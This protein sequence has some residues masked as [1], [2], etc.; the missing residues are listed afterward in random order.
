[1]NETTHARVYRG[2]LPLFLGLVAAGCSAP[3]DETQG[4]TESAIV[5]G[6]VDGGHPNVGAIYWD[7]T[8]DDGRTT[9]SI[10]TGTVVTATAIVSAAHCVVPPPGQHYS[11]YRFTLDRIVNAG[12][13]FLPIASVVA[14]PAYELGTFGG[15]YDVSVMRLAAPVDVAPARLA[16]PMNEAAVGSAVVPVGYGL[17]DG[18]ARTGSGTK[19]SITVKLTAI[20]ANEFTYGEA[21]R[22]VCGGDSGGPVFMTVDGREVIVGLTSWGTSNCSAAA[23]ATR[24]DRV[25]DFVDAAVGGAIPA[26]PT[27]PTAGDDDDD[28][29]AGTPKPDG[30]KPGGTTPAPGGTTPGGTDPGG[31]TPSDDEVIECLVDCVYETQDPSERSACFDYC[32]G[33]T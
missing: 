11:N 30:R 13:R 27:P 9:V 5:G 2:A 32:L 14:H 23:H 19:R 17:S 12:S 31:T 3:A 18:V 25:R 16:P 20:D 10:C 28:D 22:T 15:G 8:G 1:M 7:I 21:G 4:T 24:A 6:E 33:G 26:P 29:T